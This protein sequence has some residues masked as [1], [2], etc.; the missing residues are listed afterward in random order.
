MTPR[1]HLAAAGYASPTCTIVSR[2]CLDVDTVLLVA[3]GL[4]AVWWCGCWVSAGAGT[5]TVGWWVGA[6]D[7]STW[8]TEQNVTSPETARPFGPNSQNASLQKPS[9]QAAAHPVLSASVSDLGAVRLSVGSV[10]LLQSQ[11]RLTLEERLL[12]LHLLSDHLQAVRQQ[13]VVPRSHLHAGRAHFSTTSATQN[14]LRA[15]K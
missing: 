4:A 8:R 11:Q 5:M 3:A 9:T 6:G 1:R 7:G 14:T 10:D 2:F 13:L 15:F 12:L